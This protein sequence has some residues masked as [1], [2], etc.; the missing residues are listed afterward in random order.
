MYRCRFSGGFPLV[1]IGGF[2]SE[3]RGF[4]VQDRGFLESR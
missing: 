4:L 1:K 3:G 2:L